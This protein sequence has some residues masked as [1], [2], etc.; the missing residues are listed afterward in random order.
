MPAGLTGFTG[1]AA[2]ALAFTLDDAALFKFTSAVARCART[3]RSLCARQSGRKAEAR[4]F[5][6]R[7]VRRG[8]AVWLA[9]T[10]RKRAQRFMA[11]GGAVRRYA[12]AALRLCGLSRARLARSDDRR[13]HDLSRHCDD[14]RAIGRR[15]KLAAAAQRRPSNPITQDYSWAPALV[16]GFLLALTEPTSRAIYTFA[17]LALYAA[18]AALALAI[19]ARDCARRAGLAPRRARQAACPRSRRRRRARRLSCGNG[20]RRA[21]HARRRRSRAGC[22][23]A[24][25]GRAPRP[26]ARVATGPRR[27]RR[28]R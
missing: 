5:R 7:C 12:R 13:L 19:L 10:A 17:L 24:Q 8:L 2:L 22:L 26:P 25:A 27:A 4:Q 21:R 18:P 28:G 9:R 16:P 15:G 20:G 6:F 3:Y 1:L 23:R 14:G 11:A